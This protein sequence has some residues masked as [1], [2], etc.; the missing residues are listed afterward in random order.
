MNFLTIAWRN[1]R[2]RALASTLTGLSMALGVAAVICVIV[3]HGVAVEQFEQDAQG[4]HFIVGGNGGR[5]QLVLS[6]V[7]HLDKPLYPISYNTYRKF[8]D[9]EFAAYTEVAVPYCLGDSFVV[10]DRK[11][12]V[13]GTTP[14]LFDRLQ[15]DGETN[16]AFAEGGRNFKREN[17]FEAV[18]GSIAAS[19]G[20]LNVGDTFNPT[21]GIGGEGNKHREFKIV[22]ILEPTGTA[23]DRALFVNAEGF[24]LIEDHALTPK[25]MKLDW[26]TLSALVEQYVEAGENAP[27]G[28]EPGAPTIGY[29]N[30]GNPVEPL[31]QAQREV[32][33]VLVLC[34][35]PAHSQVL[36]TNINKSGS[37]IQAVAPNEVVPQFLENIVGPVR[38]VLLVLTALIVLVAAIGILVSIYNSMSERSHDIAVMRAL[39]ASRTAVQLI[40]LLESVLLSLLGGL[41]GIV[42]GH[43]MI[44]I[45]SPY[46]EART[47]ISL[48]MFSFD[49][50]ELI[51]IPGLVALAILAGML[52][53]ITAYRT[54]VA[55]ALSGTR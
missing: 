13:V 27:A 31:P 45:A 19:Q 39:G 40:V 54:D 5:M 33:S 9:G 30:A 42:L 24:Y 52:P 47:G 34:K 14:D 50:M 28:D 2:D 4:Y 10:G 17:F 37:G 20:G 29:D 48:H 25:K 49:P 22:G 15:Y 43:L 46:V 26:A 32:T 6:T 51:L 41:A 11:F 18:V 16:Y 44:G 23:N 53:A 38:V 12:R 21:H 1:M 8:V 7:Y 55:K 36:T 3:I 35:H